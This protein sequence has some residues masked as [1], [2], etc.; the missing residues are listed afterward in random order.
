MARLE[1]FPL[2]AWVRYSGRLGTRTMDR[3]Q[4]AFEDL[5]SERY[6]PA[7]FFSDSA[8]FW[9][10]MTTAWW[11]A[12]RQS[13]AGPAPVVFLKLYDD[14]QSVQKEGVAVEIDGA[15]Q[16]EFTAPFRVGAP[17]AA[18]KGTREPGENDL[19]VAPDPGKPGCI[20]VSLHRVS[21][22]D[23]AKPSKFAPGLYQ[24]VVHLDDKLVAMIQI[25]VVPRPTSKTDQPAPA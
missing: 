2:G 12:V 9:A 21:A 3:V 19:R 23:V 18:A 22:E 7:R 5:E 14:D 25:L 8:H 24:S 6:T 11:T 1:M 20:C 13:A 15:G 10:D 17:V 16:L 4:E